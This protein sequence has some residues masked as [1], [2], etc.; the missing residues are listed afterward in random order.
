MNA[1]ARRHSLSSLRSLGPPSLR[2]CSSL[3]KIFSRFDTT[4]NCYYYIIL[5]RFYYTIMGCT[6]H[7]A[8]HSILYMYTGIRWRVHGAELLRPGGTSGV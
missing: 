6:A 4:E 2:N 1:L 8:R 3:R 7:A 5:I